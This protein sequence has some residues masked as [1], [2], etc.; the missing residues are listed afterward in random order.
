MLAEIGEGVKSDPKWR[1]EPKLDGYRVLAFVDGASVRLQ[2]RRGLDLTPCFPELA[3]DLTAQGSGQM[4]LDGEIVA[5]DGGGHPSFNALQNRAQ[6]KSAAEIAV[7]QRESPVVLICFDLLHFAGLNLRGA[8]YRDRHRYLAQCLLPSRHLQLV[9]TSDDAEELYA[10]SI[11]HGFEGIIAK[12][13]DSR[14]EAG[15]RSRA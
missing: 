3:A 12:R 13:L 11:A 2:S 4:I 15:R 1:Y 7:A 6:L 10:A 14:Y 9:H 8:S 5:L